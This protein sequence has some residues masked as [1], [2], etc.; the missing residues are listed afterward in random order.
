METISRDSEYGFVEMF[1]RETGSIHPRTFARR[2]SASEVLVNQIDLYGKLN[3]H[4]GC[5]NTVQFYSTGDLLVSG[6]DDRQVMFWNWAMKKL[7]FS[8]PS[9][10]LDNI[11]QVRIMPFTD[12]RK[13]VTSSA[14]GQAV[15]R[16]FSLES[17]TCSYYRYQGQLSPS[18]I[19]SRTKHES[20]DS[21]G[22]Q[23]QLKL[24]IAA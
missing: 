17:G 22:S 2:I 6:S 13:T 16:F 11:F 7:E 12:D 1:R 21:F 19:P 10:H 20:F 4:A 23:A 5:I 14:D 9:G 15:R 18:M 8:Y 3:G 24:H